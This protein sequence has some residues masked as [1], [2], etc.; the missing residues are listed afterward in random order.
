M[1]SIVR[2]EELIKRKISSGRSDVNIGKKGIYEGL[3]N[4]IKR[5]LEQE[6]VI[7]VRILKSAFK[8]L[9]MDRKEI[10]KKVAELVGARLVTVRGHTFVLEK[11][12]KKSGGKT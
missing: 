4:E 8:V 7:K 11:V 6:K 2:R 5:R 9:G 10:A 3:L 12:R 1:V